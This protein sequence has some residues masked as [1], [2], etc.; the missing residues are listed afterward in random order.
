MVVRNSNNYRL[1]SKETVKS[2]TLRNHAIKITDKEK[3]PAE[4]IKSVKSWSHNNQHCTL[5][6]TLYPQL[7]LKL[8]GKGE[9]KS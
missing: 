9:S 8:N 6:A 1:P 5:D 2:D 7:I 3:A 4:P